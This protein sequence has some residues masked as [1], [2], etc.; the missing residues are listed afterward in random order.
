MTPPKYNEK[1]LTP[2]KNY[3][4]YHYPPKNSKNG[5]VP[6]LKIVEMGS[7]PP[8]IEGPP[9]PQDVFDTFPNKLFSHLKT[10]TWLKEGG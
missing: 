8:K 2:P 1:A 9:P 7:T 6:V 10:G 4:I 3:R 5:L